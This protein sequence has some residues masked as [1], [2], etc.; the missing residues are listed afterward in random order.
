MQNNVMNLL[1]LE[2]DMNKID[3]VLRAVRKEGSV[4]GS[5]DFNKIIPMPESLNME[6]GSQQKEG[7]AAYADYISKN[8]QSEQHYRKRHPEITD[9]VWA[10]GKQSYENFQKY[11]APTWYEWSNKH[12]GTKWNAYEDGEMECTDRVRMLSFQTAWSM[13]LP[14]LLKLSEMMP[15][16]K[17]SV[18]WADEDIGRNCGTLTIQNGDVISAFLPDWSKESVEF[19]AS[20]WGRSPEDF[21]LRLNNLGTNYVFF[22]DGEEV[23][24]DF[25]SDSFASH[26]QPED[27]QGLKM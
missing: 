20:V 8:N 2:G 9:E 3:E 17:L 14:I 7:L 18:H 15:D 12:W 5:L 27:E 10:M 21:H 11:G 24:N 25:S 23:L 22:D 16:A 19:A 1:K 4:L 13:P 26:E 6:C